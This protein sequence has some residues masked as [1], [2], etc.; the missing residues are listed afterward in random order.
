MRSLALL[1]LL[2]LCLP[3]QARDVQ[4]E[5]AQLKKE[6]QQLALERQAMESR[7]GDLNR[8]LRKLDR[9]WV[10]ARQALQKVEEAQA[11]LQRTV[12]ELRQRMAKLKQR[13]A[14]L[15]QRMQQEAALVWQRAGREP[16]W[17]EVLAGIPVTEIPHRRYMLNA[18]IQRQE[19]DRQALQQ[20]VQAL[21][22]VEQELQQQQQV[23]AGVKKQKAQAEA[24]A[25]AKLKAKRRLTQAV[26]RDVR[27]KKARD[28]TLALQ[29]KGLQKLL[30][31]IA[32]QAAARRKAARQ[33]AK[34]SGRQLPVSSY[35][36]KGHI[37]RH[38]GKLPWPIRGRLV[39]H[40]GARLDR[41]RPKLR[42]VLIA[43][44]SLRGKGRQV[45]A[46]ADGVVRYADWFGGFGLMMIV[47]HS[48]GVMSIYAHNDRLYKSIG[49][50]VAAGDVIS[51]A[52]ATGWVE[53][54]RL[55]FEMRDRGKTTNPERWCRG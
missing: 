48:D 5:L 44:A 54:T 20:S 8:Q 55:Y 2:C 11:R 40:Y 39:A 53:H 50:R 32:A 21:I 36:I 34:R 13:V 16:G 6:R 31:R 18:L 29:Q 47:E 23:L 4:S 19:A 12:K 17:L 27:L 30:E 38:K 1:L 46:I 33:A 22:L 3:A 43:P 14:L 41:N 37:R 51:D 52:G 42:G 45:H 7:L 9:Q 28:A 10:K 15:Q 24:M 25:R 26:R 49:D 35:S